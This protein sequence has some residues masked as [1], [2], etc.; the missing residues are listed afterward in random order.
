MFQL[1]FDGSL[2][3]GPAIC[4]P[5]ARYVLRGGR[6]V[7]G[8]GKTVALFQRHT[9]QINSNL[10]VRIACAA[11]VSLEFLSPGQASESCGPFGGIEVRGPA[12]WANGR[13]AAVLTDDHWNRPGSSVKWETI[14]LN[15]AALQ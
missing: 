3:C 11:S 1:A 10:Y 8:D 4:S 13:V 2:L 6:L 7:D 12:V 5:S 9:W 15:E 14:V